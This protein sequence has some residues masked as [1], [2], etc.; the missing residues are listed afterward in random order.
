MF[1][2][3]SV[4]EREAV[5]YLAPYLESEECSQEDVNFTVAHEFA[6]AML[7]HI[8]TVGVSDEEHTTMVDAG[9]GKGYLES[10]FETAVDEL[11]VKWGFIL[12]SRRQR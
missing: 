7:S 3:N 12:P 5:I 6:H 11:V 4:G 9:P 1:N 2:L 8:G 10:S